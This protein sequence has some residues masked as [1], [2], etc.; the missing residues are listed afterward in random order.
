[1]LLIRPR[2]LLGSVRRT[3]E[4]VLARWPALAYVAPADIPADN[5][6]ASNSRPRVELAR[7]IALVG[8]FLLQVDQPTRSQ[9]SFETAWRLGDRTAAIGVGNALLAGGPLVPSMD[10]ARRLVST[11]GG[12]PERARVWFKAA[13]EGGSADDGLVRA[14]LALGDVGA[15]LRATVDHERRMVSTPAHRDDSAGRTELET[16][17]R[18]QLASRPGDTRVRNRLVRLLLSRAD[19]QAATECCGDDRELQMLVGWATATAS[20]DHERAHETKLRLAQRARP[21][22]RT[23]TMGRIA[24]FVQ[25]TNYAYGPSQACDAIDGH[26]PLLAT[27]EERRSLDKLRADTALLAGDSLPLRA[28]RSLQPAPTRRAT[29]V[30]TNAVAGRRVLVIGPSPHHRPRAA[31][32]REA[33]VVVST[34][35]P[36]AL[37]Q[38]ASRQT[39]VTYVADDVVAAR[40]DAYRAQLDERADTVLV[41]RPTLASAMPARLRGHERVSM[42]TF[43]D[44]SPFLGTHFGLQR[45]LYDMLSIGPTRLTISGVDFFLDRSSHLPGYVAFGSTGFREFN[46]SHDLAY[47]FMWTQTVLQHGFIEA[48]PTL[49]K[50]LEIPLATYLQQLKWS[51][52]GQE[53]FEG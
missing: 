42:M 49:G 40:A 15:A 24:Y 48:V 19:F 46:I 8:T 39:F 18:H 44:G 35:A 50:L 13:A 3:I 41:V 12:D 33:D 5:D 38:H 29:E 37:D 6:L 36:H 9:R 20:G 14:N 11:H 7:L 23:A 25:A 26:R 45:I 4:R 21:P 1:M 43:E 16:V 27:D 32:L 47:A 53:T 17:L 34:Q 51:Y 28:F 22:A 52:E 31:D 30:L 2:S 10:A